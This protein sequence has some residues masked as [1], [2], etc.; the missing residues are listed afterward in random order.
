MS[1]DELKQALRIIKKEP[2]AEGIE[3]FELAK[4]D[5]GE[6]RIGDLVRVHID[7]VRSF[8]LSGSAC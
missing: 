6:H 1:S 7:A 8:S 2:A 5:G 3:Y 4:P